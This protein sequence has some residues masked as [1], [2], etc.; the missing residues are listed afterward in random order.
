VDF[1]VYILI[2]AFNYVNIYTLFIKY[3]KIVEDYMIAKVTLL[4]VFFLFMAGIGLYSRKKVKSVGD[5]VLGGRNVGAWLT[6]FTYG[7]T[8]FSAVI[9]IGYA[10]KFGWKYGIAAAWIGVGNALIGSMLA[11]LILG[12]R[13]RRMTRHLDA[14]TMPE[15]FEKRFGSKALKIAASC[16]IFIFLVPYSASVYTGLGYLFESAFHMPYIYC[17]IGM[18]VVTALYLILGGYIA[19][20]LSDFFQGIIMLGGIMLVIIFVLKTDVVG[21]LTGGLSQLS[22]AGAASAAAGGINNFNIF[23]GD[24]VNLFGLIILT[25]IGAWGLPQMVHK[26]YTIRD[27]KAIARGTVISTVFALIIAGG[28]YFIGAFCKLFIS[29]PKTAGILLPGSNEINFDMVMPYM[30]EKALPDLLIGVVI[31]LVLSASMST[32]SSLVLVSSS[33]MSLDFIKGLFFPNMQKNKQIA[34]MRVLCGIFVLASLIV[35]LQ[36]G[37]IVTLM[38]F[39]WGALAG[40]FLAPFFYGLFWKGTTRAGVW[41][42]FATGISITLVGF[43]ISLAKITVSVIG[44]YITPPN[45]G[46]VAMLVPLLIVP[47]VSVLTPHINAHTANTAF[48]ALIET[49]GAE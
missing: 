2:C 49:Q 15:F 7:T 29:D 40:A 21:G 11:W 6:A 27:D 48:E 3:Y 17:E 36:K 8:Y 10:G 47:L 1:Y 34:L 28:S 31:I 12:K 9:F 42:G 20:A 23:G 16:I 4:V 26:F 14:T 19:T 32:L 5:F 45:V 43:I 39:S 38:S 13:T 24:P 44:K 37:A 35:A 41:A 25:S 33:T 18:A 30:L 22:A 46:A